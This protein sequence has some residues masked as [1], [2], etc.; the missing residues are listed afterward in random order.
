MEYI[1]GLTMVSFFI[2]ICYLHWK[3][4]S[5]LMDSSSYYSEAIIPQENKKLTGPKTQEKRS[6]KGSSI[7]V[8]NPE[9]KEE[10]SAF[11][12]K[13]PSQFP[14]NEL[15]LPDVSD[16]ESEENVVNPFDDPAI[17]DDFFESQSNHSHDPYPPDFSVVVHIH[18]A[19][20]LGLQE[21]P[22]NVPPDLAIVNH[23]H[24]DEAEIAEF[25]LRLR[26]AYRIMSDD[27]VDYLNQIFTLNPMFSHIPS[28][29]G[30]SKITE[31]PDIPCEV[32]SVTKPTI[33][34]KRK[35]KFGKVITKWKK[36]VATHIRKIRTEREPCEITKPVDE[37]KRKTKLRKF[38]S[39]WEKWTAYF[40]AHFPSQDVNDWGDFTAHVDKNLLD[41]CADAVKQKEES[42]QSEAR[43]I[44][45]T[46]DHIHILYTNNPYAEGI[47]CEYELHPKVYHFHYVEMSEEFMSDTAQKD[48]NEDTFTFQ[49]SPA[50]EDTVPVM[51]EVP[52][53]PNESLTATKPN[54]G[55]IF[56][57][58][59]E[60]IVEEI[61]IPP[62]ERDVSIKDTLLTAN[63]KNKFGTLGSKLKK[64]TAVH[65]P[66]RKA[67]DTLEVTQDQVDQLA[68]G[69]QGAG[70]NQEQQT[71]VKDSIRKRKSRSQGLKE[72][73]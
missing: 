72:R 63:K 57:N 5:V 58:E 18:F 59:V 54:V 65:F 20:V 45:E 40:L 51:M 9:I 23:I 46:V 4:R 11:L 53:L 64:W 30:V 3:R 55:E 71:F 66:R 1:F 38:R 36:W 48:L 35:N 47:L 7:Y 44:Q 31:D 29:G 67:K 60:E 34:A 68:N 49:Y 28:K 39:K 42:K 56:E 22:A 70:E 16:I 37:P 73:I 52:N 62:S 21:M 8:D 26:R 12:F 33:E 32:H 43:D 6:E 17:E 27:Y 15:I 41:V 61:A 50:T 25:L 19:F 13:K 2:W 14:D 10:N 69:I 24:T